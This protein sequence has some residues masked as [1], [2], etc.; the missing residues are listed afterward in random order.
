LQEGLG[1]TIQ[2]QKTLTS[3]QFWRSKHRGASQKHISAVFE[4]RDAFRGKGST[5]LTPTP[6]LLSVFEDRH[7]V[8]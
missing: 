7:F 3:P 6:Q 2:T 5:W 8:R 4:D 1:I